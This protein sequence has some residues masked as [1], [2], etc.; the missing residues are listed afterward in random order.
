MEND[1]YHYRLVYKGIHFATRTNI[2]ENCKNKTGQKTY[3]FDGSWDSK[4]CGSPGYGDY[5]EIAIYDAGE[6]K[7]RAI[8]RPMGFK[9]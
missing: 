2:A 6:R 8:W 9:C 4:E 3:G 7:N 5:N 1:N